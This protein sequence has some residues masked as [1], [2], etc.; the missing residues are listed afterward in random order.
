MARKPEIGHKQLK[1]LC[2]M[3]S[4]ERLEFISEGLPKIYQSA[5]SYWFA[6]AHL[7]ELDSIREAKVLEGHAKE[8]AAKVLIL[9]DIVRCPDKVLSSKLSTLTKWFYSHL[10]RLIYAE[11]VS[12]R[13]TDTAMLKSYVEPKL[14]SHYIE[15]SVGE[16][17]LPN[18]NIADRESQLYVDVIGYEETHEVLWHSPLEYNLANWM[19]KPPVLSLIDAMYSLGLFQPE[20]LMVVSSI[21]NEVTFKENEDHSDAGRLT[22]DVLKAMNE[23]GLIPETATKE[24]VQAL[25]RNWQLPMYDFDL[26][27]IITPL[28]QLKREQDVAFW[29]EAG[30]Y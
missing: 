8:E 30:G 28:E 25:Y 12:W 15:G 21:W 20:S 14:K 23:Q 13:P 19:S 24:H 6:A 16:Y 1:R 3:S 7:K 17:I 9:M 18:F 26:K 5:Q 22:C 10:A 27:E 2:N 29:S 4:K 11:A